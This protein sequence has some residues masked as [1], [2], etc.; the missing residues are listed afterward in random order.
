MRDLRSFLPAMIAIPCESPHAF[1][2]P[3][4]VLDVCPNLR[5]YAIFAELGYIA[6]TSGFRRSLVGEILG[7]GG[8]AVNQVF[9]APVG[10]VAVKPAFLNVQQIR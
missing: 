7:F 5:L 2:H 8:S 4:D 9:M 10:A 3:E 6:F 1:D